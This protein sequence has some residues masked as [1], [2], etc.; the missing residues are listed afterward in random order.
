MRN[1]SLSGKDELFNFFAKSIK[2][3]QEKSYLIINL[4]NPDLLERHLEQIF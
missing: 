1:L 2:S 3:F 4:G